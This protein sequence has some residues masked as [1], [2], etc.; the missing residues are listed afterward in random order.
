[1][2]WFM[3]YY[4]ITMY[5]AYKVIGPHG[6]GMTNNEILTLYFLSFII[7][8]VAVIDTILEIVMGDKYGKVR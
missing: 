7:I 4:M 6:E 1:M 5:I 3:I 8:P 2:F